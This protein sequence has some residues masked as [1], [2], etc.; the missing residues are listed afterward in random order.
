MNWK[1]RITFAIGTGIL[2]SF[3]LWTFNFFSDEKLNSLNSLLFQGVF[4]GIFFGIG[5]PYVNEKFAG[6]LSKKVKIKPVLE[7]DEQIEIEGP[8]NLFRGFEGVGGKIFLTNKK[9]IFKSHKINIQKGQTDINYADIKIVIK[10]KT[11]K[12]ID[13]GFRIITDNEKEYDFVVN[14]RDLWLEKINERIK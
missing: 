3:L 5:F 2:Y 7:L 10:R 14:E 6:K 11:A 9:L 1:Y 8:A 4:F 12:L 13:N